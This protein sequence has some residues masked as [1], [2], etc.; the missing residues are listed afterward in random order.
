MWRRSDKELQI[1]LDGHVFLMYQDNDQP[2]LGRM[3]NTMFLAVFSTVEKLEEYRP[4]LNPPR[5]TKIK[6]VQEG[7]SAEFI[8]SIHQGGVRIMIDP[9]IH[10]GN[11]RFTMVKV[12]CDE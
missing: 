8:D 6:Q 1:N 2:V 5:P 3:G 12:Q 9:Y 7:G 10:N 11:T 4:I